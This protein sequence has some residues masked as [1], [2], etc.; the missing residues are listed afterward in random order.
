MRMLE[1]Q[2]ILI[3]RD[4]FGTKFWS[5]PPEHKDLQH[6]PLLNNTTVTMLGDK[7]KVESGMPELPK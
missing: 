3:N 4:C 5:A 2:L 7:H 6:G 1:I